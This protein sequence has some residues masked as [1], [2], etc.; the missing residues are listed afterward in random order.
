MFEKFIIFWQCLVVR[1]GTDSITSQ[2]LAIPD[3][4]GAV[5]SSRAVNR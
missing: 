2:W 3:E 1:S 5:F 4:A